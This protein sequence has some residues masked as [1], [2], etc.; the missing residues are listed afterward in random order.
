MKLFTQ[1]L[2][3]FLSFLSTIWRPNVPL[4]DTESDLS[5]HSQIT[6]AIDPDVALLFELKEERYNRL[7]EDK[8]QTEIF[9]LSDNHIVYQMAQW[10]FQFFK[11]KLE[12]FQNGQLTT[13]LNECYLSFNDF[14]L[15]YKLMNRL[16]VDWTKEELI[17]IMEIADQFIADGNVKESIVFVITLAILD[18]TISKRLIEEFSQFQKEILS[19]LEICSKFYSCPTNDML[20]L[21]YAKVPRE[22]NDFVLEYFLSRVK[23]FPKAYLNTFYFSEQFIKIIGKEFE[24]GTV[25]FYKTDSSVIACLGKNL[26][27]IFQEL[28][29]LG[30]RRIFFTVDKSKEFLM[31]LRSIET[32]SLT[33]LNILYFD[34]EILLR[35]RKGETFSLLKQSAIIRSCGDLKAEFFREFYLSIS[36]FFLVNVIDKPLNSVSSLALFTSPNA[37]QKHKDLFLRKQINIE[38]DY[39][40]LHLMKYSTFISRY[41][42]TLFHKESLNCLQVFVNGTSDSLLLSKAFNNERINEVDM[43][44]ESNFYKYND[45]C[46]IIKKKNFKALRICPF[47][48]F[49]SEHLQFILKLKDTSVWNQLEILRINRCSLKIILEIFSYLPL[50]L[51]KLSV[52]LSEVSINSI[53]EIKSIDSV[54]ELEIKIGHI[55]NESFVGRLVSFFPN[56]QRLS[57][58]VDGK[59]VPFEI[60]SNK[61]KEIEIKSSSLENEHQFIEHLINLPTLESV[62]IQKNKTITKWKRQENCIYYDIKLEKEIQ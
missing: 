4:N 36:E 29:I 37:I 39:C 6:T 33:M 24:N 51:K 35:L 48:K 34:I 15:I 44:L 31:D 2:T 26:Q 10:G 5:I 45:I 57:I 59:M 47:F 55:S 42:N 41:E 9:S 50:T 46:D 60:K 30:N 54:Q 18:G 25:A 16:K 17:Q 58:V 7:E 3:T 32:K 11:T 12:Y 21:D 49:E 61:L 13:T 38:R 62:S 56:L 53:D 23:T 22:K 19:N 52:A 27:D 8:N 1:F 43:Q 14:D 40:E 28:I 20:K